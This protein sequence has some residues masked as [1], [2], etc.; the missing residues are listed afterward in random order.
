MPTNPKTPEESRALR[1]KAIRDKDFEAVWDLNSEKNQRATEKMFLRVKKMAKGKTRIVMKD[2]D[3]KYDNLE[4]ELKAGNEELR[5]MSGKQIFF[6]YMDS[7]PKKVY[8]DKVRSMEKRRKVG[9][10][11][12]GKRAA[13]FFEDPDGRKI[14]E[15]Y[16]FERGGWRLDT[17]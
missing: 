11:T 10:E 14:L 1:I 8:D 15:E 3:Q 4:F 2:F 16:V 17:I 9:S 7:I 12:K 5:G 13:L 6:V